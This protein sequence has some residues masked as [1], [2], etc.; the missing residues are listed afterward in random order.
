M[1]RLLSLLLALCMVLSLLPGSVFAADEALVSDNEGDHNYINVR[2]WTTPVYSYLEAADNGGFTRIE[3]FADGVAVEEYDSADQFVSRRNLPRELPL[4][5]GYFRAGDDRFLVF[6]QKNPDELDSA[7]VIRVVKYDKAWNRIADTRICGANTYIPFEAGSLRMASQNGILYVLTS[8]QMYADQNGTHH[9]ANAI[10]AIRI[11]DMALTDQYSMVMNVSCGY[12]SHSFN[13]FIQLDGNRIYAL[14]HGDAHP[15]SVVLVRYNNAAG[16]TPF[17]GYGFCTSVDVLP[18][19]G[20]TGNNDTGVSVGGFVVSGSSFVTAGNSMVQDGTGDA[21]TSQRNVYLT[22]TSKQNFSADGT[23]LIW[24]TSYKDDDKI[25]VSNP[26]LVRISDNKLL[27]L[28]TEGD[29]LRYVF[30]DGAGKTLTEIYTWQG[31]ALSDCDPIVNG[32]RVSWYV[33]RNS[34]PVFYHIDL[35]DPEPPH[36]HNYKAVVTE[37]TCTEEGYTTYTCTICGDSYTALYTVALGHEPTPGEGVAPTCTEEGSTGGRVC[38]RCGIVLKAPDPIPALGHDPIELEGREPTCTLE[39]M[40]AGTV[41]SRCGVVLSAES[42][43]PALGHQPEIVAGRAPTCTEDGAEQSEICQRCGEVL[44][45]GETI[46]ALGHEEQVLAATAPTCTEQG[47]SQGLVCT[48]CG[49]TLQAQQTIAALGHDWQTETIP[50]TIEEDG[51]MVQTCRRCGAVEQT[52]L[53]RITAKP[54][55]QPVWREPENDDWTGMYAIGGYGYTYDEQDAALYASD[56]FFL[57]PGSSPAESVTVL[58]VYTYDRGLPLIRAGASYCF[59][60]EKQTEGEMAGYYTIREM[61]AGR[62]LTSQIFSIAYTD[63]HMTGPDEDKHVDPYCCWSVHVG[64]DGFFHIRNVGE[65]RE[66][67]GPNSPL[68]SE[69]TCDFETEG[70][71]TLE[72]QQDGDYFTNILLFRNMDPEEDP[73]HPFADVDQTA[74]YHDALDWAIE[75]KIT[76][77]TSATTFGPGEGCTRAQVVTFLWRAAGSPAPERTDNPFMD[78]QIDDYFYQAVLWAVENGITVGTE[79]DRFSPGATC[80][81]AQIVTFLYRYEGEPEADTAEIG[82]RDVKPADYFAPSVAWAVE[83]GITVGTDPGLFSPHATCTRAQVVTF[84]YRDIAK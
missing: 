76:A 34:A 61:A 66:Y 9:Q 53:P 40:S 74:F 81:R 26:H 19:A 47:L 78:V 20:A 39:G 77:G 25:S 58:P 5:G 80:T 32:S 57:T 51:M 79:P 72:G 36:E 71:F 75:N 11:R 45:G 13:Q 4:F 3:A 59:Y 49:E 68:Y 10:F 33:T 12:V 64:E 67:S 84:L 27:V 56:L 69:L 31:A 6:G 7:E 17:Q 60:L 24:L 83:N 42:T 43:I 55:Y 29:T 48:R 38:S 44:S 18:I 54:C 1:K 37:P 70:E 30:T 14:N 63:E 21:W 46:P 2:R 62:Y 16:E 8:H 23:E 35:S 52:V 73:C 28:W 15:R 41:C 22:V 50:A 65:T 82:F